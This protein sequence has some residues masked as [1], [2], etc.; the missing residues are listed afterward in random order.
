MTPLAV[1]VGEVLCWGGKFLAELVL[2]ML[3]PRR[4]FGATGVD[5]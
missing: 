2:K 5:A 4:V 3:G 1:N